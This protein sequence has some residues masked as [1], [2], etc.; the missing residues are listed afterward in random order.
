MLKQIVMPV[1]NK[2]L[3]SVLFFVFREEDSVEDGDHLQPHHNKES[4]D[5]YRDNKSSTVLSLFCVICHS[6]E[7]VS[8]LPRVCFAQHD[9][10]KFIPF[11]SES[12]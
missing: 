5:I 6:G 9:Q 10:I 2:S 4:C 11:K 7:I 1:I 12:V 8:L 3:I